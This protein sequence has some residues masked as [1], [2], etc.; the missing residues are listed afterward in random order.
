VCA[1]QE[2]PRTKCRSK[3][4][5]RQ[6]RLCEGC[7]GDGQGGES[8][9]KKGEFCTLCVEFAEAVGLTEQELA[10]TMGRS[11]MDAA[12][13]KEERA[14]WQE[15][16][17]NPEERA[18]APSEVL[19]ETSYSS[20]LRQQSEF[21]SRS[22]FKDRFG[23]WPEVAKVQQ[24]RVQ[25]DHGWVEG[26]LVSIPNS[27]T[28]LDTTFERRLV[29]RDAV[30]PRERNYYERQSVRVFSQRTMEWGKRMG[31]EPGGKHQKKKGCARVYTDAELRDLLEHAREKIGMEEVGK[32]KAKGLE[33]L[34]TG[35]AGETGP[36]GDDAEGEESELEE[37]SRG[38]EGSVSGNTAAP[39]PTTRSSEPKRQ[40]VAAA[41]LE[42][43]LKA[44]ATPAQA[45]SR[46]AAAAL[47]EGGS[48]AAVV[49]V[50]STPTKP[51]LSRGASRC[52]LGP[53]DGEMS[54]G[55]KG[56][57]VRSRPVS[58]WL[59]TLSPVDI[60]QGHNRNR[61]LRWARECVARTKAE[62][63]LVEAPRAK[64]QKQGRAGLAVDVF[65]FVCPRSPFSS[66]GFTRSFSVRPRCKV[67]GV[68]G[69][70]ACWSSAADVRGGC[71]AQ[72]RTC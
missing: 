4:T 57:K 41:P 40:V 63:Q 54:S 8:S 61:E 11:K 45:A 16:K 13:L 23:M 31:Q 26:V 48:G 20:A 66:G 15:G 65:V 18:I 51:G 19:I 52:S 9:G 17:E 37:K 68:S 6:C 22:D 3:G 58:Y 5:G 42:D 67:L 72:R 43:A 21:V 28:Y 53:G 33:A 1:A 10:N 47:A 38:E 7:V 46:G 70:A 24:A 14:S 35:L 55:G 44:Q 36:D 12:E 34:G 50:G 27:R 32:P 59:E 60:L 56:G 39:P 62:G 64:T 29:K 49:W 2:A 30:L 71:C 25:T 69:H